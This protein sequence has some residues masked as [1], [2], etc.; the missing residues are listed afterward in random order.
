MKKY[1]LIGISLFIL[2]LVSLNTFAVT[3]NQL[4]ASTI[5]C[6]YNGVNWAGVAYSDEWSADFGFLRVWGVVPWATDSIY[7]GNLS[8]AYAG[9]TNPNVIGIWV[10]L[11]PAKIG[12]GL[13]ATTSEVKTTFV[14]AGYDLFIYSN[15]LLKVQYF[16]EVFNN[17]L[18]HSVE[19]I[20]PFGPFTYL[21]VF[22][23]NFFNG[24]ALAQ[25]YAFYENGSYWT[26]SVYVSIPFTD[27]ASAMS[28][29]EAPLSPCGYLSELP[30]I[31]G[32]MIHFMFDYVGPNGSQ[33]VGPGNIASGTT[34]YAV[35]FNLDEASP[36][37]TAEAEIVNGW[38]NSAGG[39]DYLYK[40]IYPYSGITTTAL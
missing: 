6:T 9:F 25:F 39:W 18:C 4:G 26:K 27:T 31:R 8:L 36:C 2:S 30:Y 17:K 35:V 33:Y 15:G 21:D 40:F 23:E 29:V 3:A 16:V 12:T 14:Q 32:G 28:I 20:V 22:L 7:V 37:N 11:S 1:L 13:S 34:M 38:P 19:A 5:L 24:T 10:G